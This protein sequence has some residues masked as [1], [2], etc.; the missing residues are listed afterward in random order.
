[1]KIWIATDK[2][3]IPVISE[4]ATCMFFGRRP[5]LEDG[6]WRNKTFGGRWPIQNVL[7]QKPG[8]IAQVEIKEVEE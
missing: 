5:K 4:R 7:K 3:L 2:D 8:D 1:M 6:F